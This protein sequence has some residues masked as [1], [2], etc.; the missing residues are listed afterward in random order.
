MSDLGDKLN[1]APQEFENALELTGVPWRREGRL[2]T[3]GEAR[4]YFDAHATSG[5][6][7]EI[8]RECEQV[9]DATDDRGGQPS[10]IP[11][12]SE[13]QLEEEGAD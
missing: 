10:P 11:Q 8:L 4:D 7:A 1:A 12:P 3:V 5:G 13:D 6:D 9:L 2:P